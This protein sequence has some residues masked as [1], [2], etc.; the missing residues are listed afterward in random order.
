MPERGRQWAWLFDFVTMVAV[1][2]GLTFG[3][4]EL[5]QLRTAQEAQ[6]VLEL[7]Q[8]SQTPEFTWAIDTK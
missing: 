2:V 5:R 8:T 1:L 3:A 7:Y 4:I 6:A